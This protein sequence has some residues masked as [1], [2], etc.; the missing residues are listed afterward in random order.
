[1][2]TKRNAPA[3]QSPT[4]QLDALVKAEP[5]LVDRIFEYAVELLPAIA[6]HQ[7]SI[8]L[9]LRQE[10]AGERAYIRH[11]DDGQ[12]EASATQVLTL[13]NGRNASEVA[14]QLRISRATVY[15]KLKQPGKRP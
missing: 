7:A 5:D 6:E 8:K 12:A 2:V 13:F 10:F 14:R 15:R 4:P 1:V 11:R 3:A 9:A